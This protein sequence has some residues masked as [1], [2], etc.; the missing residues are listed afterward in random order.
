MAHSALLAGRVNKGHTNMIRVT[1]TATMAQ[2]GRRARPISFLSA[3]SSSWE[4]SSSVTWDLD[5]DSD[6]ARACR[7][8]TQLFNFQLKR[9]QWLGKAAEMVRVARLSCAPTLCH[10]KP[11]QWSVQL[12]PFC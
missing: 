11:V 4:A 9:S 3:S 12:G 10:G 8:H 7:E 6:L 5:M 1:T 2:T